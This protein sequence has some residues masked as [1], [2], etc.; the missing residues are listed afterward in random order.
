MNTLYNKILTIDPNTCNGIE[1]KT[2]DCEQCLRKIEK[3]NFCIELTK[4][5]F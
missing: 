4:M 1:I 5:C 3:I 2:R